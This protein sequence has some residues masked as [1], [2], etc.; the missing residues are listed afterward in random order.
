V[1]LQKLLPR[2]AGVRIGTGLYCEGAKVRHDEPGAF[3]GA[4]QFDKCSKLVDLRFVPPA[5][6]SHTRL[7]L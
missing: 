6:P 5:A 1:N 3:L 4:Y 2:S 7:A